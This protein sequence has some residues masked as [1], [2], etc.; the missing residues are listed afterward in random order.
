[1]KLRVFLIVATLLLVMVSLLATVFWAQKNQ[2]NATFDVKSG[3][4]IRTRDDGSVSAKLTI[5]Q[6]I[7]GV[8]HVTG[9]AY[10]GNV[11]NY[12]KIDTDLYLVYNKAHEKAGEGADACTLD[13]FFSSNSVDIQVTHLDNCGDDP[14]AWGANVDFTG[15]FV[16]K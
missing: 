6:Q 11:P 10:A 7:V 1:M 16:K 13:F 5:V 14:L 15:H 3:E 9:E 4:Y 8:V 2:K 12:G